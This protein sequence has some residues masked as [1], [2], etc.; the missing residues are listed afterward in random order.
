MLSFIPTSAPTCYGGSG[1]GIFENIALVN[2]CRLKK[3]AGNCQKDEQCIEGLVCHPEKGKGSDCVGTPFLEYRFCV[4]VDSSE[5]SIAPSDTPSTLPS[6][7]PS[8]LPSVAPSL[9]PSKNPSYGPSTNPSSAPSTLP[10]GK[11]SV[12]HS[13]IPSSFPSKSPSTGPSISPSTP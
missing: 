11:P 6:N 9:V 13:S 4:E 5:P 8:L 2:T 10:S 3:C 1:V 12:A 7:A